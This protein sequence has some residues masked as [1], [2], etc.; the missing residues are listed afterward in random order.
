MA[1]ELDMPEKARKWEQEAE[2]LKTNFN[3]DFWSE[4]KNTFV[5]AL[6]GDKKP[7]NVMTSNAGHCLFSGIANKKNAKKLSKSL[8]DDKMFTGWGIRTLGNREERFNPMSYHNGSVWPHDNAIIAYGLSR[9]GYQLEVFKI[10]TGLFD[11]SAFS[12]ERLPELFCG[13]PRR[14]GQGPTAYPVACSP[15]AWAVGS[16]FLMLQAVLGLEIDAKEKTIRLHQCKLPGFLSEL[17]ITN[18][19]VEPGELIALQIREVQGEIVAK[20]LNENANIKVEVLGK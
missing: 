16:V 9:Y 18:L 2:I 19:S 1:Y 5:L 14:R 10:L 11:T 17:T 3:R 12:E 4:S 20:I 6:D 8:L 7:C 15:Q 13:F